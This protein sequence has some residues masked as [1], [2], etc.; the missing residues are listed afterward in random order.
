MMTV[1]A[2]FQVPLNTLG[3]TGL[4]L[5]ADLGLAPPGQDPPHQHLAGLGLQPL[6]SLSL[7]PEILLQLRQ[8]RL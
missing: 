6:A 2:P 1:R 5:A 8:P 7:L 3:A 4:I